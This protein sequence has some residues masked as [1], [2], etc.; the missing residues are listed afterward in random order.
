VHAAIGT[1]QIGWRL[2]TVQLTFGE[3]GDMPATLDLFGFVPE[4]GILWCKTNR[5]PHCSNTVPK[6]GSLCL[7]DML[8]VNPDSDALSALCSVTLP[9][10]HCTLITA[11]EVYATA[12]PFG[13]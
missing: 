5:G 11:N 8:G 13:I 7:R 9:P 12:F 10:C 1:L 6:R 4:A 3:A 2:S